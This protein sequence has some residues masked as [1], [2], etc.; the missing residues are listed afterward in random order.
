[1]KK[2]LSKIV[3]VSLF[4]TIPLTTFGQALPLFQSPLKITSQLLAPFG[5]IRTGYMHEGVDMDVPMWT[6]LYA[7]ADGIITKAAPDSKGVDNGG[8]HMVFINHGNNMES[9]YMHLSVYAVKLGDQVKA[10]DLIGFSG[11]SGDAT[12]PLLHYEL[13]QNNIPIDCTFIFEATSLDNK[14]GQNQKDDTQSFLAPQ[15]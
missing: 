9:R 12:R 8:G 11:E 10:G 7:V 4:I 2:C 13:R 1:M 15:S 5:Q 14:E 3:F 6:P